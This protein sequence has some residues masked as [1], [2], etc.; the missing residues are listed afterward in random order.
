MITIRDES[1]MQLFH[2]KA[3]IIASSKSPFSWYAARKTA[4][5]NRGKGVHY[6]HQSPLSFL[7]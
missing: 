4:S 5:D 2:L 7:R 3:I 1:Q 6:S